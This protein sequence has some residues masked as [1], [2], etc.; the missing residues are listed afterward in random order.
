[1]RNGLAHTCAMCAASAKNTESEQHSEEKLY[2]ILKAILVL[3]IPD[4]VDV[5]TVAFNRCRED[6]AAFESDLS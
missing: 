3:E 5:R 2:F 6:I 1:M 4:C